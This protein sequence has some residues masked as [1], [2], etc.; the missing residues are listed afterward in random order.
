MHVLWLARA[1]PF[2]L[3]AGDRIYSAR[4]AAAL[5]GAG[6]AVAFVGLAG[7]APPPALPGIDWRSIAGGPRSRGA[8]LAS[9]LPLVAAR[10]ATQAYRARLP[11]LLRERAWDAVV[12]D[13]YGAAWT[14]PAVQRHAPGAAR[15][16]VAHNH[17]ASVTESQWRDPSPPAATRAYLWQNWLKTRRLERHTAR[18]AQLIGCITAEDQARFAADA[19]GVPTLLLTPGHDGPRVAQRV[20]TAQTP[21]AVLLFGSWR[22]SAK[23]ASLRLFLDHADAACADAGIRIDIL[24]DIDPAFAASLRRFRA[25]QVHGY[26]EDPAPLLAAARLAVVA[27]PVGGGF[28]LKLLEYIFNRVPVAALDACASGLPDAVRAH[29]LLA[30][31]LPALLARVLAAIDDFATL[32]AMQDRAYAAASARFDWADRGRALLA[33]LHPAPAQRVAA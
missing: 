1:L 19:P 17:E 14:L 15:V 32:N 25:V 23:Q 6:A 7:E 27:E 26:V 31:D 20:I 3:T 18:A 4:L 21:R 33:A 30:A 13:H 22:W 28:K 24:G 12:I 10:H 2:P 16:F 11:G 29:L 9:P 8:A 5:A